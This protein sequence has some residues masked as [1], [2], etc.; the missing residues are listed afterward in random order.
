MLEQL[1]RRI[2]LLSNLSKI[3]LPY[4]VKCQPF[5]DICI[6]SKRMLIYVQGK[7]TE[8]PKNISLLVSCDRKRKCSVYVDESALTQ[9]QMDYE[10]L[11]S[12]VGINYEERINNSHL[13]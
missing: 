8:P 11:M 4:V 6:G 1:A 3:P 13:E 2:Q 9:L 5:D 10:Y 7:I 12:K